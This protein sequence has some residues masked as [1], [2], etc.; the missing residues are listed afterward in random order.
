MGKTARESVD[1]FAI[2]SIAVQWQNLFNEVLAR[3][4]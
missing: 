4:N 3:K 1:R 2:E